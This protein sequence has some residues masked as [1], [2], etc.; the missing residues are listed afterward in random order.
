VDKEWCNFYRP[1]FPTNIETEKFVNSCEEQLPTGNT[2]KIIMHQTQRLVS[3]ADDL[4]KIRPARESLQILF[5]MICT[6]T[7]AKLH[8]DYR[9]ERDSKKHVWIFFTELI[10][11]VNKKQ[12]ADGF[13]T[14]D[15]RPFGLK[16][17][18]ELLYDVR[19][20]VVHQGEYWHLNLMSRADDTPCITYHKK[21]GAF[22]ACISYEDIRGIIIR[23]A[24]EAAKRHLQ[25]SN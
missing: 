25:Q 11:N 2:S 4:P 24:I 22:T 15:F 17:T 18:V 13:T 12:I 21:Y 6:E 5:L 8:K 16:K 10:S 14:T 7:V 23:G 9:G 3:L 20:D 1:F 19:C